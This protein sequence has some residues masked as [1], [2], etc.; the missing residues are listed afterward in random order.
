MVEIKPSL[1]PGVLGRLSLLYKMMALQKYRIPDVNEMLVV[2]VAIALD[3]DTK[4]KPGLRGVPSVAVPRRVVT[5]ADMM[6]PTE[7]VI[8][9]PESLLGRV[10]FGTTTE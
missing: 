5:M 1:L 10:A 9:D 7:V 2:E 8:V 6:T 4:M 3:V